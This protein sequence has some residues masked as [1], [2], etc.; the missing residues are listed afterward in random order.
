[1]PAKIHSVVAALAWMALAVAL[2]VGGSG[3]VA[4]TNRQP[5]DGTR[6]E[7]TWAADRALSLELDAATQ[8]LA[9]LS[10]QVD[11][12]GTT[13]RQALVA[14][15]DRDVAAL[16][17]AVDAGSA[18]IVEIERAT[19]LLRARLAA[20]PVF[21]PDAATRTGAAMHSRADRLVAAL[22]A[23]DGLASSWDALTAG[24]LAAIELTTSLAEHDKQAVAAVILGSKGEYVRAL[25]VLR[26][27]DAALAT[28]KN[29]RD[30]LARTV[31]VGVLTEW[32]DRNATFDL[33]IRRVW[34]LLARSKGKVT[35]AIRTAFEAQRTAQ[36]NLPPDGRALVV[37]MADVA[38][39][40][41][42]QAVIDIEQARGRLASAVA[43]SQAAQPSPS[44]SPSPP[45]AGAP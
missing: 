29:L 43:D 25:T 9:A 26:L 30:Q 3:I 11:A 6:P 24:S 1:M 31:D 22:A 13:G 19:G 21:D 37:I 23:T 42:N 16:R 8:D 20:V 36:A 7:L 2:A 33:A 28:S 40:G 38:R 18:Q 14:L 10:D 27:A 15:V 35:P 4:A 39:G 34:T 41:I 17:G 5:G 45:P 44:L 32:I 12:L